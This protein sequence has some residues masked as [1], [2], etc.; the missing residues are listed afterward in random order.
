MMTKLVLEAGDADTNGAV[1]GA[2]MGC[3]VGYEA[4][5]KEWKDKLLEKDWLEEK[6]QRLFGL[7]GLGDAPAS[8][9]SSSSSSS[10]STSTSSAST[11]TT[12]TPSQSISTSSQPTSSD[13]Q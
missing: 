13:S 7:M 6:V 11:S 2:M 8:G 12:T 1:A 4:L 5:P 10:S 3:Q 9:S